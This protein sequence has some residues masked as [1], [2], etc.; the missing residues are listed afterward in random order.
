MIFLPPL[1]QPVIFLPLLS[2]PVIFLPLLSQ[3]VIF[4]PLLSGF[5]E[6]FRQISRIL[7]RENKHN[8]Q[9]WRKAG[10]V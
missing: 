3:P 9:S 6:K 1:S 8:G 2:Q 10:K 4:L 7:C 5:V